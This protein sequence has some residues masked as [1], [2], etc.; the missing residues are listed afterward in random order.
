MPPILW[1]ILKNHILFLSFCHCIP[2]FYSIYYFYPFICHFQCKARLKDC[3]CA[4]FFY[5]LISFL[6]PFCVCFY[7]VRNQYHNTHSFSTTI[8]ITIS[9][10]S[11]FSWF[12][13]LG[14]GNCAKKERQNFLSNHTKLCRC[15]HLDNTIPLEKLLLLQFINHL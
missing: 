7:T 9:P 6:F 2:S 12:S 3:I 4:H 11:N 15:A 8:T 10:F 1:F 14:F 5:I 13:L